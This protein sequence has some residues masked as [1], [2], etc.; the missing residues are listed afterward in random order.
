MNCPECGYNG[1]VGYIGSDPCW[2][3]KTWR[4]LLWSLSGI[5]FLIAIYFYVCREKK[6]SHQFGRCPNCG[7][8]LIRKGSDGVVKSMTERKEFVGKPVETPFDKQFGVCEY[9]FTRTLTDAQKATFMTEGQKRFRKVGLLMLRRDA[10]KLNF[11]RA[12]KLVAEITA[13]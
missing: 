8:G 2:Y 5:G 4:L 1:K 11:G 12:Q 3:A 13:V 10:T 6:F 7:N 9:D